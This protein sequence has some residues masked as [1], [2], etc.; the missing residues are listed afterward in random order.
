[1]AKKNTEVST[2]SVVKR[3]SGYAKLG[4]VIGQVIGQVNPG[5]VNRAALAVN[6]AL[7]LRT[8]RLSFPSYPRMFQIVGGRLADAISQPEI[9]R[10][11]RLADEPSYAIGIPRCGN[12]GNY[13]W[14]ERFHAALN[15]N[16]RVGFVMANSA[17]NSRASEQEIWEETI[18]N[19][20]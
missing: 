3:G 13:L 12:P 4:K 18:H 8:C 9:H 11:A 16:G 17:A 10:S 20:P 6:Q 15:A 5:M 14:N 19:E 1:M 7:V 2:S